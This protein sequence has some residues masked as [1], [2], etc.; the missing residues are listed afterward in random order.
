M[1]SLR[2]PVEPVSTPLCNGEE[3]TMLP[4]YDI[5][6]PESGMLCSSAILFEFIFINFVMSDFIGD[7]PA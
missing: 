6:K 5:S 4:A 2:H 7:A 1:D 3:L